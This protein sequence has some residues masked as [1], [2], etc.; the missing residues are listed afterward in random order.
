MPLALAVSLV[1][2]TQAHVSLLGAA[3]AIASGALVSSIGY[4]IWYA[5]LRGLTNNLTPVAS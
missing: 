2:S 5:A 4:A 1:L 3:Y